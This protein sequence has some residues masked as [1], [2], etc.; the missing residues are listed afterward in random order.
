[1]DAASTGWSFMSATERAALLSALPAER[2]LLADDGRF[3]V[4][5]PVDG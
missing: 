2:R 3:E 5:S 1:V 4:W